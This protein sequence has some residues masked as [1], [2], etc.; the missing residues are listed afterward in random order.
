LVSNA[1]QSVIFSTV[2]Q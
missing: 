2:K 1:L